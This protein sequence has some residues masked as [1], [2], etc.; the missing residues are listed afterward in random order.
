MK[1]VEKTDTNGG[2]ALCSSMHDDP[3]ARLAYQLS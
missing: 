3:H 2:R 1:H